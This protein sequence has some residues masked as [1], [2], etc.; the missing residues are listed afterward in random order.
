MIEQR[1]GFSF[2]PPEWRGHAVLMGE[3]WRLTKGNRVAVCSLWNHPIGAE[4]RCDVDG[5]MR[6]EFRD[7]SHAR[8]HFIEKGWTA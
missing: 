7:E 4:V 6:Q 5:E 2:N 1:S 3:L 8:C